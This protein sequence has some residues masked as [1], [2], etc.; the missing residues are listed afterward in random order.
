MYAIFYQ[1][2][3]RVKCLL[4]QRYGKC[5]KLNDSSDRRLSVANRRKRRTKGIPFLSASR[6]VFLGRLFAEV[7]RAVP[8]PP[9]KQNDFAVRFQ[10]FYSLAFQIRDSSRS[11]SQHSV[12]IS[13]SYH[14]DFDRV[15]IAA[16]YFNFH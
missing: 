10:S 4:Y 3:A 2:F 7:E 5:E 14:R 1:I 13:G 15:A 11:Q 9:E 16:Q 6:V 12:C 8:S